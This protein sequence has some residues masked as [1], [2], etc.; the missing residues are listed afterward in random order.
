M[1]LRRL[2]L[3]ALL[4]WP[5][6]AAAA[7]DDCLP[8]QP[9][10]L[11]WKKVQYVSSGNK[12]VVDNHYVMLEGVVAPER[13][14]PNK[15]NHRSDDPLAKQAKLFLL[16]LFANHDMQVGIEHDRKRYD[17]F[18]R[19][20][21]HLYYRDARGRL[22]SVQQALLAA[23]LALAATNPPNLKH[24]K[25]YYRTEKAA[26]KAV[27]GIWRVARQYPD[28]K[29]P[30]IPSDRID[31]DDEG[32]RIVRGPVKRLVSVRGFEGFNLDTTGIR[33]PEEDFKR[34]WNKSM[35]RRLKG[36]TI[37]VRGRPYFALGHMYM[38]VRHPWAIDLLNPVYGG[39]GVK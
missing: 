31:G 3:T 12:L 17:R 20:L 38:V 24:Q 35:L 21:G 32:Y 13:G 27:R 36:R 8:A 18:L 10:K 28:L 37:E 14:R 7:D 39:D 5:L 22:H 26:R 29:Y 11:V 15:W 25:C 1:N 19:E 23:G 4:I 2:I 9:N 34:Y 33:I 6:F 16:K 30:L